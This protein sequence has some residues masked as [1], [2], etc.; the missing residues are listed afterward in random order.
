[1]GYAQ[2]F[3]GNNKTT[4]G[5]LSQ[6]VGGSESAKAAFLEEI[7]PTLESSG[8]AGGWH[9]KGGAGSKIKACMCVCGEP[10]S[11]WLSMLEDRESAESSWNGHWRRRQGLIQ[12]ELWMTSEGTQLFISTMTWSQRQMGLAFSLFHLG[13]WEEDGLQDEAMPSP[14][15]PCFLVKMLR[16]N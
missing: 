10:E 13:S 5:Y 14:F 2:M 11:W 15:P 4:R 12:G 3:L 7:T 6:H 16:N 9:K 1:M 8:E